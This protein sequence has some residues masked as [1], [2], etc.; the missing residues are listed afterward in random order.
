MNPFNSHTP[1]SYGL[2]KRLLMLSILVP[3][4]TQVYAQEHL[5]ASQTQYQQALKQL[6]P[7]DSII[8]KNGTWQDFEI[9]F[10]AQ[11]TAEKPVTLTAQTK[12]SVILSG[13]SNLQLAG[14]Y[15]Q[16]SG[17]VFKDGFTPTNE[18][19]AF[20]KSDTELANHSR[21]T[22]VVIDNYNNPDR[23]MSDNWIGMYGQHNRLD[24]SHFVGKRNAGVTL[25]VRLEGE[26]NQQNHHRIDHNY[27]GPRPILGSNGGETIRIGTSH[28]SL[29]NS[30]TV[31][32]N[33]YFD[34]CDG[35]VE[36]ISVK[37][38]KNRIQNNLFYQSRGTLTLRHGNGNIIDSNVFLGNGVEHTG[39][40]RIINRD[41]TITNNY[42]EGLTGTRF[43][44]GFT[45]MNGVPNSPINRY[46]QVVNANVHHNSFINLEHI[47]LAAGSDSERS[48]PPK[49]STLT[50]NLFINPHSPFTLYDD[51]SGLR[52]SDNITNF[53]SKD[54][55][56]IIKKGV[57]TH[58]ITLVR[59][60]NGLLYPSDSK[61]AQ[62]GVNSTLLPT[63]TQQT[64]PTW[65]PKSEP[66]VEFQ[67]GKVIKVSN[68]DGELDNAVAA[69]LSGDTLLLSDGQYNIDTLLAI[70]K[71]LTFKAANTHKAI[72]SFERPSLFEIQNN[73]NLQLD[74]LVI[75]GKLSPD[76]PGN[77]V[78]RTLKW[79]MLTNY[80]FDMSNSI[81][82]QLNSS[83]TFHFFDSGSRAFADTINV[84]NSQFRHISGDVFRLNKETDDIG[85]YNAEYLDITHNQFDDIVGNVATVYRGGTDESTFGPHVLV[86][87]NQFTH[88]GKGQQNQ[89]ESILTLHGVQ[90]SQIAHNT[91]TDSAA[92]SIF[93]TVGEP[94]TTIANNQLI[95]TPAPQVTEFVTQGKHTANINNNKVQTR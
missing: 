16:V 83:N 40:I 15:L 42:L 95:N 88:V 49:D 54:I 27:F 7:G 44:S 41:Q 58:N 90:V 46:H 31:V 76:A 77:S 63:T 74:G 3:L 23:Q 43:G 71:T 22:E 62:Y 34:R 67:S 12:G 64:G 55:N 28:H 72:V 20:K 26:Q 65:Y 45:I 94:Q 61:F 56:P 48:A 5:V 19:I 9:V 32:E 51:I 85:I 59:A 1:F 13:Q 47:E 18:V 33:N 79:G 80:R 39:G 8:L 24:H 50:Q 89:T 29:T 2:I 53:A 52:F 69:A 86:N 37:S 84:N 92:I 93:H 30:F 35:E 75:N 4:T 36:I 25:A 10:T 6:Q 14:E 73:G 82:E 68:A 57:N 91:F 78:I 21:I 60:A 81:V 11:G 70:N 38:G 87:H 17:L 66:T